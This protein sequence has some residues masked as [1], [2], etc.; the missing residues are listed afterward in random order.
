MGNLKLNYNK[1]WHQEQR[2]EEEA[3]E[4][5]LEANPEPRDSSQ[6]RLSVTPSSESPNQLFADS[7]EEVES[8]ESPLTSTKRPVSSS[9]AS[10]RTSS[11]TPSST[12]STPR[13]RLSPPSTSSTPSRDREEPFTDSVDERSEGHTRDFLR[14]YRFII[15]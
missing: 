3:K 1:Q 2:S 5:P 8:R 12:P 9:E 13:E 11:G 14:R 10:S 15:S 4:S 7:Q 6:E